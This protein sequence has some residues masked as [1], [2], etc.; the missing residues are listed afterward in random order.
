MPHARCTGE[1]DKGSLVDP[2]PLAPSPLLHRSLAL[3]GAAP[4]SGGGPLPRRRRL[5]DTCTPPR[6][7]L[8]S[9]SV[10]EAATRSDRAM[11]VAQPDLVRAVISLTSANVRSNSNRRYCSCARSVGSVRNAIF[12]RNRFNSVAITRLSECRERS[13]VSFRRI[14]MRSSVSWSG[15]SFK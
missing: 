3:G 5:R 8:A 7:Y 14:S 6:L 2:S 13:A 11:G 15:C 9:N 10:L 4:C 12:T 1:P